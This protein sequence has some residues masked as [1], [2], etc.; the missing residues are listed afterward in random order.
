MNDNQ[1]GEAVKRSRVEG[2][3]A[4]AAM[5]LI[6][7]LVI[8]VGLLGT[9]TNLSEFNDG[10]LWLMLAIGFLIAGVWIMVIGAMIHIVH[11]D[12]HKKSAE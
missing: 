11:L 6:A 10:N 9:V 2:F 12:R 4:G 7:W 1:L 8:G 3:R 5:R